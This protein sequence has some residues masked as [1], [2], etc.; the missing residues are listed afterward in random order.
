MGVD[1][2]GFEVQDLGLT[3]CGV[4]FVVSSLS[5]ALSAEYLLQYDCSSQPLLRPPI[6]G[7]V[8]TPSIP[9]NN[10]YKCL[11]YNPQNY[12]V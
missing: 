9:L 4:G 11:L 7:I 5:L 10:S 3:A 12:P 1:G 6:W 2:L 8:S